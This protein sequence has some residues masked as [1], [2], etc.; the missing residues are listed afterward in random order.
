MKQEIFKYYDDNIKINFNGNKLEITGDVD[1]PDK[2]EQLSLLINRIHDYALK[3]EL[4]IIEIDITEL[5]Y[6]NS[7]GLGKLIM[8]AMKIENMMDIDKYTLKFK[9]SKKKIGRSIVLRQ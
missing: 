9:C 7:S 6:I 4:E 2:N 8:W 5:N 1:G 3:K